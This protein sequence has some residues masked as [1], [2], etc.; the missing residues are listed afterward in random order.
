MP[1]SS[2]YETYYVTAKDYVTAEDDVTV[3]DDVTKFDIAGKKLAYTLSNP[4]YNLTKKFMLNTKHNSKYMQSKFKVFK[5]MRVNKTKRKLLDLYPT[6][7]EN[8]SNEFVKV[9]NLEKDKVKKN[10]E[11]MLGS[12]DR[13]VIEVL[14]KL[15]TIWKATAKAYF[16]GYAK[17][18]TNHER[19]KTYLRKKCKPASQPIINQS[20]LSKKASNKQ[21]IPPIKWLEW[22]VK[23]TKPLRKKLRKILMAHITSNLDTF[24]AVL[25]KE[26]LLLDMLP[27]QKNKPIIRPLEINFMTN[28]FKPKS[29]IETN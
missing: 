7:I 25:E 22:T 19:L 3:E 5:R 27:E 11:E 4:S 6:S 8:I 13:K 14:R 28:F 24:V 18:I 26:R 20:K 16:N 12:T 29:I 1:I 17:E 15:I 9:F 10:V 23:T 21:Q 2:F